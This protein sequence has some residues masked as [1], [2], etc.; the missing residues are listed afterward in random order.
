[1]LSGTKALAGDLSGIRGGDAAGVLDADWW[2]DRAE[3]WELVVSTCSSGTLPAS[4]AEAGLYC[5]VSN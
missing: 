5:I 3:E 2:G 1:M 4:A